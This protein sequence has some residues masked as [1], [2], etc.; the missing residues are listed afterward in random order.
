MLIGLVTVALAGQVYDTLKLRDGVACATLGTSVEVRDELLALTDPTVMPAWV[1]I[2]AASCL[3]EEFSSDPVVVDAAASWVMDP[4]RAGL[5]FV[6][7][8]RIDE[9]SVADGVRISRAAA[10][11]P[12]LELRRRIMHRVAGSSHVELRAIVEGV[13]G[14]GEDR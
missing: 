4:A 1:P 12:D 14:A 2:R 9:F 7:A 6:V 10:A 5:G 8:R 11:G 3:V 13:D